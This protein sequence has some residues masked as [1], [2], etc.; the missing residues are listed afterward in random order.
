MIPFDIPALRSRA[1][2]A[3]GQASCSP[4]KLIFLHTGLMLALGLVLSIMDYFLSEGIGSTGGLG[5]IGTRAAL[6]TL[7]SML[8]M[9]DAL[10]LPFWQIGL[11]AAMLL[12]IR[13]QDIGTGTLL[14]GF[15]HFGPVL[16]L[17]LLRWAISFAVV[18]VA[19]QAGT[20]IFMLTPFSATLMKAL[21]E[22]MA[23]GIVDPDAV[24]TE[25]LM[26]ELMYSYIPIVLAA[27][28]LLLIPVSYRLRMM[29]YVL[30]DR[31]QLGAFFALRMSIF[32]TRKRCLQLFKLDLRFWWFYVLELLAGVL[33]YGDVLLGLCGVELG[34]GAATA[35]FAFYAAGLA[36]QLGLYVW[37][38]DELAA[39][40]A[41]AYEALLPPPLEEEA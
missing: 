4:K 28:L 38:K 31:P 29:D 6:E 1:R 15:R 2:D 25:A 9:A 32:M 40:Y 35:S 33:C 11:V 39:T 20:M 22:M 27:M 37:K 26:A 24:L 8:Q 7:R 5:G 18:L 13:G 16:R 3:L 21:E 34:M 14:E 17:N 10:L 30:M 23:A 12:L 41:L 36:C 19:A